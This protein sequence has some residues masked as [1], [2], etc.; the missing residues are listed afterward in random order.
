MSP[1]NLERFNPQTK[2]WE[3]FSQIKPRTAAKPLQNY[4]PD[5]SCELYFLECNGNNSM[6]TIRKS[7]IEARTD[8]RGRIETVKVDPLTKFKELRK[9]QSLEIRIKLGLRRRPTTI[10]LTHI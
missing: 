7:V 1:L 3:L 8:P 2:N 6:S 4:L 10:K 9:G 5:G